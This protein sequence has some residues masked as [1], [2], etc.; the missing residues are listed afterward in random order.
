[1]DEKD[2]KGPLPRYRWPWFVLGMVVLGFVLAV[3]WMSV[4]VHRIH[5]ERGDFWPKPAHPIYGTNAVPET[6]SDSVKTNR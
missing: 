4:L 2:E 3:V 5:E 6:N 1:M